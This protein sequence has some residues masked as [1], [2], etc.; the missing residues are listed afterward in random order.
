MG[1]VIQIVIL[2]LGF[3]W[4]I[5]MNNVNHGNWKNCNDNE[6]ESPIYQSIMDQFFYIMIFAFLL[7]LVADNQLFAF[8]SF[9][10]FS[11]YLNWKQLKRLISKSW[12]F[13]LEMLLRLIAWFM[14]SFETTKM[15][16]CYLLVTG[17]S[18]IATIR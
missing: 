17:L 6:F 3:V 2:S 13:M 8:L 15:F 9:L 1:Q 7:S 4:N 16:K 11:W 18:L 10:S 12:L 14:I 5:L